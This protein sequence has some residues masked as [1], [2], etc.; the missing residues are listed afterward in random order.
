MIMEVA[1]GWRPSLGAVSLLTEG[2]TVAIREGPWRAEAVVAKIWMGQL[3]G[4][5]YIVVFPSHV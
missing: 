3:P 5:G 2:M 4:Y 1:M